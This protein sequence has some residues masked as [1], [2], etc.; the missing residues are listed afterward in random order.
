[1]KWMRRWRDRFY[2]GPADLGIRPRQRNGY[3][4]PTV[5]SGFWGYALVVRHLTLPGRILFLCLGL[6]VPYSLTTLSMPIHLLAFGLC[7]FFALD[8]V[9]GFLVRPHVGIVRNLPRRIRAGAELR[10]D[11]SVTN[12]GRL[13]IW[14]V[15]LDVLPLPQALKFSRGRAYFDS[16]LAGE[17]VNGAAYLT[18]DRR[19]Q[20][21][22]PAVRAAS[23]FPFYLWYWG[24]TAGTPLSI[25]V[26]PDFTPLEHVELPVGSRYQTG[27]TSVSA[28]AGESVEFIGC[29]EFREGDNLRKLHMR[30]WARTGYPVV[31]E[32]REEYLYRTALVLDTHL[33][34]SFWSGGFDTKKADPPFEA[35]VSLAAAVTEH[36][37]RRDYAI[38]IFAAGRDV[39]RFQGGRSKSY[40]PG[41]LDILACLEQQTA[42]GF[43][44]LTPALMA[45][46]AKIGGVLFILLNW[47]DKRRRL[48]QQAQLHGAQVRAVFIHS[49]RGRLPELPGFVKPVAAD[50]VRQGRCTRI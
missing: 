3:Q 33:R 49:G 25:I 12:H 19:G 11:Y 37:G 46:I 5:T 39:Y 42:D 32:F 15:W 36:L 26:H 50:D 6:I 18:A 27:E 41:I 40:M 48:M 14:D 30:S 24:R 2:A 8:F 10:I 38:D 31:K 44:D 28:R 47:D 29:R 21:R 13:P 4:S 16:I 20:Y 9:V 43:G 22:V 17:T 23:A 35:A 7:I 45:E 1:M 34:R